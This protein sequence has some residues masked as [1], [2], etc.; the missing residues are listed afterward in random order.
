MPLSRCKTIFCVNF[1]SLYM[2]TIMDG[3]IGT[4]HICS[5][6]HTHTH[7]HTHTHIHIYIQMHTHTHTH[8]HTGVRVRRRG[9]TIAVTKLFFSLLYFHAHIHTGVRVFEYLACY[10]CASAPAT[11]QELQ[12]VQR[13]RHSAWQRRATH[14]EHQAASSGQQAAGGRVAGNNTCARERPDRNEGKRAWCELLVA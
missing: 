1:P 10:E 8:T 12:A 11:T 5:C 7:T 9:A 6:I 14:S 13:R 3:F 4:H 2:A